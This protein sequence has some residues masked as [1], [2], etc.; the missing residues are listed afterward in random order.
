MM[1]IYGVTTSI[2]K[3]QKLVAWLVKK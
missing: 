3:A 1:L 2:R